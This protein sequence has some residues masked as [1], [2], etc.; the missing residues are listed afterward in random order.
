M[1]KYKKTVPILFADN[2]FPHTTDG[3]HSTPLITYYPYKMAKATT[4][5]RDVIVTP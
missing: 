5:Y 1:Q 4:E 3:R 2:V